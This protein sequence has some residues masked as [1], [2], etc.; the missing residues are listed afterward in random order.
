MSYIGKVVWIT[1]R[2]NNQSKVVVLDTTEAKWVKGCCKK[3][4]DSNEEGTVLP[5]KKKRQISNKVWD[6]F[7]IYSDR[8]GD[9]GLDKMTVS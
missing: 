2:R 9:T 5:L 8:T 1:L 7:Q 4:C 6:N 3:F